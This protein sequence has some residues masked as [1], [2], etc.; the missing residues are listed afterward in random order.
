M[1]QRY[2]TSDISERLR[3]IF[4]ASPIEK[5]VI[6]GSYAKGSQTELSDVDIFIDSKGKLRGIDFFGILEDI[7]N[8]LKI[9]VDLIEAS[10]IVDGGKVQREISETGIVIYERL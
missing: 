1:E 3:P 10:D 7:V 5:A 6:F 8:T 2:T 9:P 4:H